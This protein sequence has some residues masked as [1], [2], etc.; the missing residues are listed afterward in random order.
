MHDRAYGNI[1]V[2]HLLHGVAEGMATHAA[3]TMDVYAVHF[4]IV[5]EL[6]PERL[7][8]M[9]RKTVPGFCRRN[10]CRAE[11][12]DGTFQLECVCGSV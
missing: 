1:P 3:Q 4:L 9:E 12:M 10:R 2:E 11:Y 5:R 7:L 8:N 6:W